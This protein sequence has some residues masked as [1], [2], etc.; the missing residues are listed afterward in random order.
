MTGR[1]EVAVL[2]EVLA[3]EHAVVYGY[4]VAGARLTGGPRR[5]AQQAWDGHRARRDELAGLVTGLGGEPEPTATTYNLP[6]PV[7]SAEDARALATLLE[8]RLAAVWADAVAALDGD[9]RDLAVRGLGEAAVAAARWRGGSVAFPGL[10]E[11]N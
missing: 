1:D 7:Q 4:G 6:G 8:E 5:R 9:L 11:R 2:Q 3:A 10:P